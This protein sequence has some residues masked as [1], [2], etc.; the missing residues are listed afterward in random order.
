MNPLRVW[1]ARLRGFLRRDAIADEIREELASHLELR[2][3]QYEREGLTK[4]DAE[5]RARE[6]VGNLALYQDRGY[7]Q[8]GGGVIDAIARDA[9]WA[10]RGLRVRGWRAAVIVSLLGVTLAANAVVFAAADAFVFRTVP[11]SDPDRL[12]VIQRV[13]SALGATDYMS[14]AA[15]LSW[16]TQRDLFAG[17]EGHERGT[18]A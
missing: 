18:P 3:Q 5:R 16:R 13:S 7:D 17:V 1:L 2:I 6:R 4:A 15:L 8:R 9:R 10:W 11:Y 12:V 14:R